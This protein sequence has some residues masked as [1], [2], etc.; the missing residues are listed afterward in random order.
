MSAL[1][2]GRSWSAG[3][4]AVRISVLSG[5]SWASPVFERPASAIYDGS[6][7]RAEYG[8]FLEKVG[9]RDYS[10][11]AAVSAKAHGPNTGP[12]KVLRFNAQRYQVFNAA[13]KYAAEVMAGLAE[14]KF[15]HQSL[16]AA[17]E[18][19]ARWL[20]LKPLTPPSSLPPYIASQSKEDITAWL[21]QS[22]MQDIK[23]QTDQRLSDTVKTIYAPKELKGH[24][25]A[26][27]AGRGD[28]AFAARV[29]GVRAHV[30]S[31]VLPFYTDPE[32]GQTHYA[33][34]A[35][36]ASLVRYARLK[37]KPEVEDDLSNKLR[38]RGLYIENFVGDTLLLH[39]EGNPERPVRIKVATGDFLS[40]RG[41]AGREAAEITFAVMPDWRLWWRAWRERLFGGLLPL[42]I[43]PKV[44]PKVS[45]GGGWRNAAARFA[46]RTRL[47]VS[48]WRV[49]TRGY[50]HLGMAVVEKADGI[51]MAWAMDI[52]PNKGPGGIRKVGIADQFSPGF[53]LR[54][55]WSTR[56]ADKVWEAFRKQ[57]RE[58]GYREFVYASN[59]G[60]WPSLINREEY[61]ALAAIPRER[62]VE[63]LEA[64]NAN[65][66]R[67]L[68]AMLM[69]MGVSF[70]YGFDNTLGKAYCSMAMA[71]AHL[72]GSQFDVQT[73]RDHWHPLARFMAEKGQDM[74]SRAFAPLSFHIDP[75][76]RAHRMVDHAPVKGFGRL[77]EPAFM[78]A[79]VERDPALT[80]VLA[81]FFYGRAA[82]EGKPDLSNF[83]YEAIH[84]GLDNRT[85]KGAVHTGWNA[86]AARRTGYS[87]ALDALLRD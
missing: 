51:A 79:Y 56:G 67:A 3:H 38:T 65:A 81:R 9:F 82:P 61:E 80:Q 47:W 72:M 57:H 60:K 53:F 71:L 17:A 19:A 29:E 62:A 66:A 84:M 78:P 76:V 35:L 50:T 34:R 83:I 31:L 85:D 87:A 7:A 39:D 33:G 11:V 23:L 86:G 59:G 44:E 55:G 41:G 25:K 27:E 6:A 74:V 14:Q 64:I 42:L 46:R 20:D 13:R 52:Y 22:T 18:L 28:A 10:T 2:P 58:R 15:S 45:M 24:V 49:F 36:A 69:T 21:V 73:Y 30:E 26:L 63:L 32:M 75:Q 68:E 5:D 1:S 8:V 40:E 77:P 37:G 48:Q 70:A 16:E 4:E 43:N 54:F 12:G